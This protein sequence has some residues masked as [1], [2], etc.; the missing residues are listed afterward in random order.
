MCWVTNV[1]VGVTEGD[2]AGTLVPPGPV[3]V[4]PKVYG[5]P[6]V[7]PVTVAVVPEMDDAS[8]RE[9]DVTCSWWRRAAVQVTVADALP[10]GQRWSAG[11]EPGWPG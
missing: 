3:A 10:A 11:P 4:T 2:V 9:V 6:L 1:A 8:G 7:R 5:V